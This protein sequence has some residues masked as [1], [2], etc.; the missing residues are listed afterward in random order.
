M[1]RGKPAPSQHR[2]PA[3]VCEVS[4]PADARERA[5]VLDMLALLEH[6]VRVATVPSQP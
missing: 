1:S 3:P 2:S 5:A 4:Q 6:N